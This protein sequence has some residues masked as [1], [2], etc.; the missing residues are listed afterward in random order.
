MLGA[1]DYAAWL[2]TQTRT[3]TIVDSFRIPNLAF[4]FR[5]EGLDPGTI[6]AGYAP[7]VPGGA[8]PLLVLSRPHG[9]TLERGDLT[10]GVRPELV[11]TFADGELSVYALPTQPP[12]G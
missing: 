4:H 11:R 8:P 2:R 10:G 1:G 12:A 7:Q 6:V 3:S 5:R 9:D